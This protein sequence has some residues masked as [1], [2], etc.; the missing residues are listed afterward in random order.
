MFTKTYSLLKI[1]SHDIERMRTTRKRIKY[2]IAT[3][4]AAEAHF[5]CNFTKEREGLI[6]VVSLFA[7]ID[8]YYIHS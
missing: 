1:H 2:T 4:F 5:H 7:D 8:I 3:I 6:E